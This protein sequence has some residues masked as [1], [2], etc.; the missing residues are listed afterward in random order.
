[1]LWFADF[2]VLHG[3]SSGETE[4]APDNFR[5]C[6]ASC[7]KAVICAEEEG[8]GWGEAYPCFSGAFLFSGTSRPFSEALFALRMIQT[9]TRR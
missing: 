9:S 8:A 2:R 7:A 3:G 4:T 1:M 6:F 5:R